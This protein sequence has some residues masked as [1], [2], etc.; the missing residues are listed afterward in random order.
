MKR[1]ILTS[2]LVA[3]A[4]SAPA[5]ADVNPNEGEGRVEI[6]YLTCDMTDSSNA[7]VVS[8]QKFSCIF[9]DVDGTDTSEKYT[10]E[11]TKY[12]VDLSIGD[13]ES[14]RWAVL[15][16]SDYEGHGALEGRYAGI[17]A[18]AAVG[19]SLGAKALVGG[20]NESI[21][22][23]PV[24]VSTGEGLGAALGVESATLR[25]EGVEKDS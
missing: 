14:L 15:A 23:Q 24:S 22:L 19:Y 13:E 12:G 18:D 3:F 7:I 25:F 8:E 2:A 6:G 9:S 10:L 11:I 4:A 21:A 1:A 16:S 17:S 20:G 5:F